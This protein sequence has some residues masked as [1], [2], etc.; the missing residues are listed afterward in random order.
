MKLKYAL[1]LN[2]DFFVAHKIITICSYNENE[3]CSTAKHQLSLASLN[4]LLTHDNLLI[5]TARCTLVQSAVLLSHI[6]CPSVC[7]SVC[8][9]MTFRYR[10]HIGW[11]S[12]KIISRPNS[13]R[14]LLP[15]WPQHGS[16]GATGTPQKSEPDLGM[17]SMFGR[18]GAPTKMGPHTRTKK[19]FCNVPTYFHAVNDVSVQ[20][21]MSVHVIFNNIPPLDPAGGLS[22]PRPSG[23]PPCKNSCGRPWGPTFF[24]E[25]GPVLSKSGPGG[26]LFLKHSVV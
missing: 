22:S 14:P 1:G 10:D 12:S 7:S 18:T 25:Q 26:E 11:N 2:F 23:C 21:T 20:K 4:R 8:L 17:F 5:F 24:S 13:L 6:V 15:G 19:N 16:S 9:S 3:L